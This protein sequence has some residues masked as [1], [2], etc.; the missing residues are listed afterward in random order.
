MFYHVSG[1]FACPADF[2]LIRRKEH[3][4]ALFYFRAERSSANQSLSEKEGNVETSP[5]FRIQF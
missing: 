2:M 4:H 3:W 5:E 1:V